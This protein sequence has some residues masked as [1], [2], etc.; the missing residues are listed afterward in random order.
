MY[1]NAAREGPSHGLRG[2]AKNWGKV[3]PVVPELCLQTDTYTDAQTD[4]QT[5]RNT[6]LPS[7][8]E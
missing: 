1:R 8:A 4:R 7:E 2:S 5:D 6:A 3:S